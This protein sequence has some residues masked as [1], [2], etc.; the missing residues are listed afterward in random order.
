[1]K[2]LQKK[3]FR[4]LFKIDLLT[5]KSATTTKPTIQTQLKKEEKISEVPL[6]PKHEE[7]KPDTDRESESISPTKL[8]REESFKL[9][10]IEKEED[11]LIKAEINKQKEVEKQYQSEIIEKEKEISQLKKLIQEKNELNQQITDLN[12][13][14]LSEKKTNK[15]INDLL[16][17]SMREYEIASSNY[18][19]A[20]ASQKE[21]NQKVF[22][23]NNKITSLNKEKTDLI[24]ETEEKTNKIED[25]ELDLELKKEEYEELQ[26]KFEEFKI[27]QISKESKVL[28]ENS[29]QLKILELE[30][31]ISA[32]SNALVKIDMDKTKEISALKRENEKLLIKA[33]EAEEVPKRDEIIGILKENILSYQ[34][35]ISELKEELDIFTTASKMMDGLIMEKNK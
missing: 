10:N 29:S 2:P 1:M 12:K 19:K 15:E 32:L 9:S 26:L 14:I 4:Q 33:K 22:D 21:L 30:G 31:K 16:T 20:L 28:D 17:N 8:H 13:Q 34:Q 23:L 11:S 27:Q 35:T 6:T 24:K 18:Q 5:T 7:Q 3:T 25:I